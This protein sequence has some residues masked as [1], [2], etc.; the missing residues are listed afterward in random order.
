MLDFGRRVTSMHGEA[1]TRQG[2]AGD[3][4]RCLVLTGREWQVRLCWE[5]YVSAL[6]WFC[7]QVTVCCVFLW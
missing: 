7:R 5:C 2:V 4:G 1:R 3:A 6:S